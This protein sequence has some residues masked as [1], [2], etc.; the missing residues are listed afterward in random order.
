MNMLHEKFY[1]LW[2]ERELCSKNLKHAFSVEVKNETSKVK[3]MA[4]SS[5]SSVTTLST[6]TLAKDLTICEEWDLSIDLKLPNRST[7]EWRNIFSLYVNTITGQPD[8]RILAVFVRLDY[9]NVVLMISYNTNTSQ[10]DKYNLTKKVDAGNWINLKINQKREVYEIM[11]DY[12]LVYSK[13]EFVPKA[14]TNMNLVTGDIIGKD[15]IS[16]IIHYRKFK[17]NSCKTRGNSIN[18][19]IELLYLLSLKH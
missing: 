4:Y 17:I 7:T 2:V 5:G 9:S 8:Q 19:L 15:N 12:K 18:F 10:S 6:G 14:W 11:V 3:Q 16:T 13:T 1:P